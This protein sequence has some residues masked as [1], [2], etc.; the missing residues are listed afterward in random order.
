MNPIYRM[1]FIHVVDNVS[2]KLLKIELKHNTKVN[3]D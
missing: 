2:I 3:N 1:Q